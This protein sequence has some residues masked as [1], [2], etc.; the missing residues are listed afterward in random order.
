[1]VHV[2]MKRLITVLA[3]ALAG[4]AGSAAAS[5]PAKPVMPD[6]DYCSRRDADPEKCVIQD[7]PPVRHY[8]RKN[9]AQQKS[10]QAQASRR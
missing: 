2:C 3:C 4:I 5:E 8:V 7:S 10:A 6:P 1:M 9:S